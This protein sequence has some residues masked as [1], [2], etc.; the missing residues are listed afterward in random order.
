MAPGGGRVDFGD[1]A[2][3]SVPCALHPERLPPSSC[4]GPHWPDSLRGGTAAQPRGNRFLRLN[5]AGYGPGETWILNRPEDNILP[6]SSAA[7][8]TAACKC[9]FSLGWVPHTDIR[10]V[11]AGAWMP[12]FRLPLSG[13]LVA[14]RCE[15]AGA[16]GG[17]V[18]R[19]VQSG[20][21]C[22]CP[23][24]DQRRLGGVH[25]RGCAGRPS[26]QLPCAGQ[27]NRCGSGCH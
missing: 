7:V 20:G 19:C 1:W 25:V 18:L 3:V 23:E 9:S 5:F 8:N 4:P 10:C 11:P 15:H 24:R 2:N 26:R 16:T 14:A 22:T 13:R 12:G 17:E 21:R 6:G 27:R